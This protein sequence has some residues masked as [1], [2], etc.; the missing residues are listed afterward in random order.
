MQM[1]LFDLDGTLLPMNQDEFTNG[2]FQFLAG[3]MSNHGYEPKKLIDTVW[4]GTAAMVKN[5]GSS[6]NEAAFWRTFTS[7]Y[8]ED[9]LADLGLFEE[10]YRNDFQ[11]AK[12]FCGQNPEAVDAVHGLKDMG[13]RVALATNPLFPAIATESRIRWAGLKPEDFEWYTTYEN[14]GFCKPNPAY[15]LE[16]TKH[17]DVEP[18]ECLMVGNDVDEDMIAAQKAGMDVFLITD[19]LLN[20]KNKDISAYPQGSFT[21]LMEYITRDA[22]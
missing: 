2:Y 17:L 6:N 1:I 14:I 3:K 11:K 4:A 15:Y 12:M 13:Y 18:K 9:S 21:Q 8:G 7:I 10:F 19:C 5:D 16:M 20:R 22:T